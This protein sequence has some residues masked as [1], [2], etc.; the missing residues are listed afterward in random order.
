MSSI[1]SSE[2]NGR[3]ARPVTLA[4]IVL[5]VGAMLCALTAGTVGQAQDAEPD[6]ETYEYTIQP[7]DTCAKIARRVLGAR[8]NYRLIHRYNPGMGPSPHRLVAGQKLTLPHLDRIRSRG[9]DA[10]VTQVRRRVRA[11]EASEPAWSPAQS[12]T[13]LFRGW[14]VNTLEESNA[15]ITF[16]DDSVVQMRENTLVIIY[17]AASSQSRRRRTGQATLERGTLRSR[18]GELRMQV[19]TPTGSAALEGGQSV[20]SVDET[21]TSRL[22]NLDGGEAEMSTSSGGRV[23]VRPGFGSKVRRGERRPMRPR[24]LPPAPTWADGPTN[25][26]GVIQNGGSLRGSW[27][28]VPV[29]RK[30]RVE[31]SSAEGAVVAATEVAADVNEFEVHR[32]PA[33]AYIVRLSTIDDDFFESRPSDAREM[34]VDLIDLRAP[35]QDTPSEADFDPTAVPETPQ[36]VRGTTIVPPDGVECRVGGEATSHLEAIG[37]QVMTC[38][39]GDQVIGQMEVEVNAPR[40]VISGPDGQPLSSLELTR[41]EESTMVITRNFEGELAP[42]SVFAP[43]GVTAS[44]STEG[45]LITTRVLPSLEAPESF[46]LAFAPENDPEAVVGTILITTVAPVVEEVP[47]VPVVIPDP[48]PQHLHEAFGLVLTPQAV[49]LRA[50]GRRGSGFFIGAANIG[51]GPTGSPRYWRSTVGVDVGIK[52][53]RL[54]VAANTDFGVE[55][56]V[57]ANRGDRDIIASVGYHLVREHHLIDENLSVYLELGAWFPSGPD[58]DSTGH[59]LALPT[60]E[61]S[62]LLAHRFHFRTRQTGILDLTTDGPLLWGSAYGLDI[63]LIGPLAIGAEVDISLGSD[64]GDFVAGVAAGGGISLVGEPVAFSLGARYSITDDMQA[65]VGKLTLAATLRFFFQ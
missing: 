26:L 28:S 14:R 13:E 19:D 22:S 63:R 55:G 43:P 21:G 56:L 45:S 7:G 4:T 48:E 23:R 40:F 47:D 32:L 49:G 36:V 39:R 1:D 18:L 2:R 60:I 12:G 38:T 46:E 50:D 41:G 33:G 42:L 17:G 29:A 6:Y 16:R 35:G 44:S 53:A 10:R 54:G 27:N 24:P 9:P 51:D 58:G 30:Y 61:L 64:N 57:P 20:V 25:F 31:I 3:H 11:R 65:R 8:R 62:Y 5:F 52:N 37:D 34:S 59:V 15:E